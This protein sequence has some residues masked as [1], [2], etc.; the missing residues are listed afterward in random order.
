[1][2][3]YPKTENIDKIKYSDW[4]NLNLLIKYINL[5]KFLHLINKNVVSIILRKKF[6]IINQRIK[7]I[8]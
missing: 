4:I 5:L 3:S 6:L 1:M 2:D 8:I 7:C